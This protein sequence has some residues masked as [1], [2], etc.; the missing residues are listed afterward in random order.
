MKLSSIAHKF[1][2]ELQKESLDLFFFFLKQ[3]WFLKKRS[4]LRI[5]GI[6]HILYSPNYSLFFYVSP[7]SKG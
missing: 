7:D 6:S 2:Y 3:V 1:C 4:P 5:S